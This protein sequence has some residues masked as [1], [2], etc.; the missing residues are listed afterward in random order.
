ME[1]INEM[2][3]LEIQNYEPKASATSAA[4][5]LLFESKLRQLALRVTG[6]ENYKIKYIVTNFVGV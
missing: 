5:V 3:P 2:H 6:I 1:H 4:W